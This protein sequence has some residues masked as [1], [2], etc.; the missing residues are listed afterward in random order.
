MMWTRLVDAFQFALEPMNLLYCLIGC[1][2]GT[3]VGV[4]PGLGPSATCAMLLTVTT[5]LPPEA[6]LIM[7]AGI[8]YGSQYG[9]STTSIL[10]NVP[11]ESSSVVT[12]IDG[13]EMTKQGRAGE[14]LA[15]AAIGSF[16]AGTFGT[17]II[18]FAAPFF[19]NVGL[20]FGPPEYV[21]LMVFGI[22]GV[23]SFSGESVL[24][25]F[26]CV[27]IGALIASIGLDPVSG[28]QR[29]TFGWPDL[30]GGLEIV[31]VFMGLFGVSEM[32]DSINE[33]RKAVFMGKLGGWK[34][35]GKDLYN[36]LAACIRG[37]FVGFIPGLIPGI[38]PALTAFWAYDVEKR[39]SKT[40]ERFGRGAIEGVAAPEAANN[41]TAQAGFI[42]LIC[43]GIPTSATW[44][45][46]L[47]ALIL[48]GL[49]PGPLLFEKHAHFVWAIIGSMYIGNVMLLI[50]NLPLVGLWAKLSLVPYKILGPLVLGLCFI[51]S[52]SSRNAM[53]DVGVCMFFGVVGFVMKKIHW[54]AIAL[55]LGFLLGDPLEQSIRQSLSI[56]GG[57]LEILIHSSLA[58]G[59]AIMTLGMALVGI[60]AEVKRKQK[61]VST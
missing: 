40:P 57:N 56:S 41:A 60:Y 13:F 35:K 7:L 27:L 48:H 28:F 50:L 15:I 4:M 44:A 30:I 1:I 29:L 25:A 24:K 9:G 12:C 39:I 17:T 11:G 47:A 59:I 18:M 5:Q 61:N 6:S 33:E 8:Y 14:A 31:S 42:P 54:P 43:F 34:P 16:M 36:G 23:V 51:G 46:V 45:I 20:H 22:T 21:W 32:I 55:V 53:F 38:V 10:V 49:Q 58:K 52:Y 19:A 26:T 2:L 3:A 37:T